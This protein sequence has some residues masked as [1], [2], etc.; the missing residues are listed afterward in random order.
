MEIR[1]RNRGF[2][3]ISSANW[4]RKEGGEKGGERDQSGPYAWYTDPELKEKR[5]GKGD[6]FEHL[7]FPLHS[8]P[9]S[10]GKGG[11]KKR[12]KKKGVT[13]APMTTSLISLRSMEGGKKEREGGKT[14]LSSYFA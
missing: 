9:R 6:H 3:T 10:E 12:K 5:R 8:L 11:R 7:A 13:V 1:K 2:T 14:A 4:K